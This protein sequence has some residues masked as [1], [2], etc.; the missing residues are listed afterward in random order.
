M[1]TVPVA[2]TAGIAAFFSPC[3]LPLLPAWLAFLGAGREGAKKRLFINLLLFV[4]GFTL[5]F[6]AM[7]ASATL[8][9]Q[10]LIS[11]RGLLLRASGIILFIFGLQ[12]MGVFRLP[13]LARSWHFPFSAKGNWLGYF[14]FG[15][16]LALGWTPCTGLIL[17]PILMMAAA[18]ATVY[19]GMLLLA[20]YSLGFALPFFVAGFII[21]S[22]PLAKGSRRLS[23]Y[24]HLGAG[25]VMAAMGILLFFNRW[26]WLQSSFI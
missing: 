18:S 11:Y 25:L 21:G 23:R 2:F 10:M 15:V 3:V 1:M 8:L 9:G 4:S 24:I 12:M 13:F 26:T 6:T 19:Q 14:F 7:G 17:G 16:I 20:V 5:I 22:V